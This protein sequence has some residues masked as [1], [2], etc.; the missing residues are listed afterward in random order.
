MP[1][2]PSVPISSRQVTNDTTTPS[3]GTA[4]RYML[5]AVGAFAV[6]KGWIKDD[7]L[8]ALIALV[9]VAAPSVYGV[10]LSIQNKK[11]LIVAAD[12]ARSFDVVQ[13]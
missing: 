2:I 7:T 8:Q 1:D 5:T 11:K 9:T 6:G 13:K 3:I 12:E 4:L 10:W